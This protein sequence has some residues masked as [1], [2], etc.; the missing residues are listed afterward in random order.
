MPLLTH[1]NYSY[2]HRAIIIFIYVY[3]IL[4]WLNIVQKIITTIDE[5]FIYLLLNQ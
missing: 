5:L 1:D 3:K 2:K 4:G